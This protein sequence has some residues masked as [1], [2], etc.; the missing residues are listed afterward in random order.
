[1]KRLLPVLLFPAVASAGEWLP[2]TTT[3]LGLEYREFFQQA[4]SDDQ[5]ER[6]A[7]V[8]LEPE[9]VWEWGA[10]Q[11]LTFRPFYRYDSA[12]EERTHGD[13]RELLWQT[14]GTSWEVRAGVGKVFW[15]V[16]ESLHLVD[17][18]NQ[19]DQVEAPD[20]EDKLGQPMIHAIWLNDAGTLEGFVLPG[21]R[22]RTFAGEEGRLSLP[23]AVDDEALYQSDDEQS[24]V[25]LALRWSRSY[26]VAGWPLDASLSLFKGTSRDPFLLPQVAL[27]AGEPAVVGL[28]AYYPQLQ[29]AGMTLQ[30]TVDSWLW[31]VEAVHRD[32]EREAQQALVAAGNDSGD[33]HWA[34]VAGFEYTLTGPF[35]DCCELPLDLGL[36]LEYQ[37]DERGKQASNAQNDVFIGTRW[38]FNDMDSSELLAGL[39]Q[40]MTYGGSRALKVEAST[41]V[42]AQS[43]VNLNVWL[44]TADD[45]DDAL[46]WSLRQEDYA[47]LSWTLYF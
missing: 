35:Y 14:W 25:D 27:V 6:S 16:T 41:R 21:F 30:S 42:T 33:D 18:I 11:R 7:S 31:K 20:G 37:Y 5:A 22:E 4:V 44:F 28:Q 34:A 40:D 15:G 47:E 32:Y 39:V 9:M 36:I 2:E 23:L 3:Q 17:V 13:I 1:M 12:D 19:T 26:E 8:W 46:A 10:A 45:E 24:H 38:A 43:V 29:Q